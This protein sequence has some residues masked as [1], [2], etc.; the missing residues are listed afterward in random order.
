MIGTMTRTQSWANPRVLMVLLATAGVLALQT[1]RGT[2][3]YFTDTA[4]ST[5][6]TFTAGQLKLL[7]NGTNP[8][9]SITWDAASLSKL[10]PGDVRYG[11]FT[12]TNDN[13]AG[14]AVPAKFGNTTNGTVT[15]TRVGSNTA[16]STTAKADAMD[17]RL[18][19]TIKDVDA[20][21]VTISSS[22]LCAAN[23]TDGGNVALTQ[24]TPLTT[25]PTASASRTKLT[26]STATTLFT[27]TTTIAAGV[28][29]KYCV[30]FKW[31]D[32]TSS[33][34]LSD[35]AAA[36]QGSNAYTITFNGASS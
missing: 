29:K 27:D 20:S 10:K 7:F 4:S 32:G 26:D 16:P 19:V 2:L 15:I 8:T 5:A 9:G 36:R 12:V 3:A 23:W 17:Q 18:Q 35:D 30:E 22:A 11:Y 21:G 31:V 13:S 14:D 24:A 25:A 34:A 28:A 6:N 33:T 1:G